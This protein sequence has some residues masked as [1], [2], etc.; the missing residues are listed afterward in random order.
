MKFI[1]ALI[2]LISLNEYGF[3]QSTLPAVKMSTIHPKEKY[4]KKLLSFQNV[5]MY[6][7]IFS[8]KELKGKNYAIII[9]DIWNGKIKTTDTLINSATLQYIGPITS[10][11]LKFT[12]VAGKSAEKKI[13]VNFNFD[14]FSLSKE[15]KSINST[16]YSFRSFGTQL[17]IEYEKPFYAFAFILPYEDKNGSKYWCAV[18]SSGKD[19]ESW[20]TA[21]GIKHYILYEMI[22]F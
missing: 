5:E 20:G 4:L 7:V 2:L 16:D 1:L 6:D 22:F 12:V 15:F 11:S 3:S 10:D 13:K 9:K 8:G 18:E 19:I 17:P 14:R 21:F